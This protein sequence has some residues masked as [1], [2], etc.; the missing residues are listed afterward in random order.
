M[1]HMSESKIVIVDFEQAGQR[2]DNF[3]MLQLKGLP[4]ARIYRAIRTGEVRVNRG[5]IKPTYRIRAQDQVRIPPIRLPEKENTH[6]VPGARLRKMIEEQILYEDR[7]LIV[8]DKPSGIPVHGGTAISAGLIEMLREM[9]PEAKFLELVHR[10]DR[11]TSGCLMI[12]K[13]RTML[14]ELHRLLTNRE[15]KK[16]YLLLVPSGWKK[17]E[18]VTSPLRKN[19]LSSG[20]RIVRICEAEGKP[21]VT[22]FRAVKYFKDATLVMAHPI[23]GRTHQIRVHAASLGFPIAGDEKYGDHKF[24]QEMRQYG[25]KRLFL[26][27]ASIACQLQSYPDFS[28]ICATL[29]SDLR[30]L[31]SKLRTLK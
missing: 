18:K 23:T 2:I 13:K 22:L 9:R 19:V 17:D 7:A 8:I 15:L 10:L 26:H 11:E 31:L 27:S 28:G 24:N 30:Q 12:A 3:L 16:A 5:R 25:L 4:K 14:V 1:V 6:F 29:S 21:A 20:E